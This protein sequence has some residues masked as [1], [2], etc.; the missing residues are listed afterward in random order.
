MIIP[1]LIIV[2]ILILGVVTLAVFTEPSN[3]RDWSPDQAVLPYAE[4]KGSEISIHNIRNFTYASTTDYTISYYDKTFDLNKIKKVYYIV[5]PFSGIR[6]AAH[7]F[8]SFEFENDEFIA[9]SVEIRKEKGE[10]FSALKGL[11]NQYEIMYVVADEKDAVKLRTNYRKDQV[12]VYPVNT[13]KEKA[14]AL[15]SNVIARINYLKENPEF[16]NSAFNNCTTN[17]AEN[18]NTITPGKIPFSLALIL[19]ESSDKLAYDLGLIDTDLSFGEAR[20]KFLINDRAEKYADAPDFS[21]KI[22]QT[23]PVPEA[24]R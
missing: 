13:T 15:F 16:Y 14:Q 24:Q 7:T 4:V 2:V 5:E 19:P 9:V 10:T 22:R 3:N 23:D 21:V 18:V 1:I 11:L 8:L 20:K 17:I 12:F 6:G